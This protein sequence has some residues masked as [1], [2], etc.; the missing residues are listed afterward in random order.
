M[1]QARDREKLSYSSSE[2]AVESRRVVTIQNPSGLHAR[3][4]HAV[5]STAQAY[6]SALEVGYQGRRV[7]GK[8]I[9]ELMTLCAAQGAVLELVGRGA[10][11]EALVETLVR[12]VESGFDERS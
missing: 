3:P 11:A 7:N 9:L 10:D 4:C 5:A 12:L 1:S 8:S 2:D 6:T